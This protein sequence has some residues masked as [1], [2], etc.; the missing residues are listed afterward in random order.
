LFLISL[1]ENPQFEGI[2]MAK[3]TPPHA[4]LPPLK[5]MTKITKEPSPVLD[6]NFSATFKDFVAKCLEKDPEKVLLELPLC[7]SL[8]KTT[9]TSFKASFNKCT[10]G[11]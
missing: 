4:P 6:G 8:S 1:S 3:G 5:A 11:P 7:S 10:S 2:E 9:R